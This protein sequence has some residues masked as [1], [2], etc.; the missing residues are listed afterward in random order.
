MT[1]DTTP[2]LPNPVFEGSEKRVEIDFNFSAASPANG[3]RALTRAQLDE[4][5]S[6]AACTIVSSRTNAELDAYVLSESSLFVYP[7]KWVLKTCGTTKLLRAVPR[8]L[9][10]A[11]QL[12][13]L[14]RRCKYSRASF[15][16][17][18]QQPFPHTSFEHEAFFLRQHFGHLGNGG[19]AYVLGDMFNGLQWHVY[20][21]DANGA[22]Y[23]DELHPLAK[24]THK[25]EVCMTDL[26]KQAARAF[27]RDPAKSASQVTT[28]TGIRSLVPSADIDDYVFEP[29]GYSMNGIAGGGFITIHITPEDGFSYASVEVSG[30]D[31]TAYDPA[32]MVSRILSIFKPGKVSVSLSVDV[33]SSSGEYSWGT[34]AARPYGYGCQSAT[35]QELATGG[36]V[37][38]YTFSP[39]GVSF[40]AGTK[41]GAPMP[42]AAP[43]AANANASPADVDAPLRPASPATVLRSTLRHMPSFSSLPSDSDY[44]VAST[45]SGDEN[46]VGSRLAAALRQ[47]GRSRSR[48]GS[49]SPKSSIGAASEQGDGVGAAAAACAACKGSGVAVCA[50]PAAVAA[51]AV[52]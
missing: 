36:R 12:S 48:S 6:L 18:E 10:M 30:F 4:L 43:A 22:V 7:T 46:E 34:L 20:V 35:C 38:Y 50:A 33:A 41:E 28:E 1:L 23:A 27:F 45:S 14:P 5:M 25:L 8:L 26:G 24:P 40:A 2:V 19:S 49:L 47:L 3:L 21:A 31:P 9:E 44:D 11:A 16:F 37:A 32:D 42:A 29:C 52:L 15:L 17:P 13:M 39:A 51:A